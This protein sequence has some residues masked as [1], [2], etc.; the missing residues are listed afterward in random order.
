MIPV[1]NLR[2]Q[3]ESLK[4]E[5]D[6]ATQ[7]VLREGSF[8]QGEACRSFEKEFARF[9][10]VS[11]ACG[12]A[13]GSDALF[14][15]LKAL[16]I[17]PGDE[18]I[19]SPFSFIASAEAITRVG[20]R[21]VF[22]DID[23]E[24]LNLA[25]GAVEF[26]LTEKTK[27]IMPVHLYGHPAAMDALARTGRGR[28]LAI[29]EDAAQAHG[30]EHNGKRVGGLGTVGCFSFYPTKNLSAAGDAGM[31][32]SNDDALVD[33]VRLLANH[34]EQSKY[35]HV[36]EGVSSRLDNLQAAI[37]RVKLRHLERWNERRRDLAAI[38]V[39]EL[40]DLPGL[41]L[42]RKA[43]GCRAVYHQFTIRLARRDALRT[44]LENNGIASGIHYPLPL[45]LQPAYAHLGLSKGGFPIAEKAAD[46]VL[47]LP[48]YP[49][50][51]DDEA[52]RIVEAVRGFYQ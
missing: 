44:H 24:T 23:E 49:E 10:G 37:L 6:A 38:Y 40:E 39:Q 47:S 30:A 3:Y 51:R 17:G 34:G 12:L 8:I 46:E 1:V 13:S 33:R 16:E 4:K 36:S 29:V 11:S 25:P 5:I 41:R 19:T 9:C 32:V 2:A 28:G 35:Q 18:V 45:H 43:P 31:L 50:L 20:A 21:V 14:L 15:A 42:P 7:E 26:G 52:H 27:A 48:M 22:A